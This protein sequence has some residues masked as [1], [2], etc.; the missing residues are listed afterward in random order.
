MERIYNVD[1]IKDSI[2]GNLERKFGCT[3][4]EATEEQIY[5]A[6]ALTVRDQIMDKFVESRHLRHEEKAR[7]VY[8]LSVEFLMGRALHN[9]I[10]NLVRTSD[11]QKALKELIG[12]TP[13]QVIAGA[14]LGVLIAVIAGCAGANL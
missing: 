3:L 5:E 4:D 12:H 7:R 2:V 14:V 6:V 9:N 1:W 8:Y 11:Y 10:L 13:V